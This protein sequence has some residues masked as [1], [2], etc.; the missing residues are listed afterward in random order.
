M[1]KRP[2]SN[3]LDQETV[4]R[5]SMGLGARAAKVRTTVLR[6]GK[7]DT[8]A[9]L[10]MSRNKFDRFEA[11]KFTTKG[12]VFPF[13]HD[14]LD[15]VRLGQAGGVSLAWLMTGDEGAPGASSEGIPALS[16]LEFAA[17]VAEEGD[18]KAAFAMGELVSELGIQKAF[19]Q[20]QRQRR[21]KAKRVE[22]TPVEGVE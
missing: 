18:P 14:A 20:L 8:A 9:F 1:A 2:D 15:L 4:L 16:V 5:L 19:Y 3:E 10:G 12:Q 21:Q 13:R 11:G 17:R 6:W 22:V 7:A